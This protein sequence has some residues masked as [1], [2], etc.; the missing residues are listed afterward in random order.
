MSEMHTSEEVTPHLD[1]LCELVAKIESTKRIVIVHP[2]H[3]A[4]ALKVVAES[5]YPG[6]YEVRTSAE[7]P[8][9]RAFVIPTTASYL[10]NGAEQ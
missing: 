4:G 5:L 8:V 9:D 2:D 10:R 7:C 1:S 6:L 3:E